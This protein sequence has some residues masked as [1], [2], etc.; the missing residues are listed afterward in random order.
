MLRFATRHPG[1]LSPWS[2]SG[3]GGAQFRGI[4]LLFWPFS[5]PGVASISRKRMTAF[6]RSG[7]TRLN[8]DRERIGE[9]QESNDVARLVGP[10][11]RAA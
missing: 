5:V 8:C 7:C 11:A 10:H 4:A 6:T 3:S 1:N 2:R 9:T